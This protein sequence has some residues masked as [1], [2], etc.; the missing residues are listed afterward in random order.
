MLKWERKLIFYREVWMKKAIYLFW[1]FFSFFPS[2]FASEPLHLLEIREFELKPISY[3]WNIELELSVSGSSH[4]PFL[5]EKPFEVSV[6]YLGNCLQVFTLLLPKNEK[7]KI[8]FQKAWGPLNTA[9]QKILPGKYQ[10][11]ITFDLEKQ[12]DDYRQKWK[13]W[14]KRLASDHKK[15]KT[16]YEKE[17]M[18]GS[19]EEF[20][21]ITKEYKK[22]YIERMRQL[23]S[24]FNELQEKKKEALYA[25]RDARR[26]KKNYFLENGRF[27][28]SKW[29]NWLNDE[30]M[31]KIQD[32]KDTLEKLQQRYFSLRYPSSQACMQSY[33]NILANI[34]RLISMEVYEHYKIDQ[35]S[36]IT[37]QVDPYAIKDI[38]HI[39]RHI[40]YIHSFS[41]QELGISLKKELGYLP[42][43]GNY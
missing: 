29:W 11:K 18:L 42:P 12:P 24:C 40:Q 16:D 4:Y 6:H 31:K 33:S 21:K 13:E 25:S 22:F 34:G 27:S 30:Y 7:N 37:S 15:I 36:R 35:D 38:N 19:E 14:E 17:F 32:E 26:G 9:Y 43:P 39:V 41:A 2:L 23:N 5:E 10:V 20:D 8:V 3:P 1:F 28:S